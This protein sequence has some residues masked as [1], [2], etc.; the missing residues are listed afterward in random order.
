MAS[1]ATIP[2]DYLVWLSSYLPPQPALGGYAGCVMEADLDGDGAAN[3]LEYLSGANPVRADSAPDWH[4]DLA[5]GVLTVYWPLR[6]DV[7]G[8][9]W[10]LEESED[11][12]VWKA[13]DWIGSDFH[14][15]AGSTWRLATRLDLQELPAG[16]AGHYY[17]VWADSDPP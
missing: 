11:L 7:R 15:H 3:V 12:R 9:T 5:D 14:L 6:A 1:S 17:R 13:A 4:I 2:A 8:V 10:R 16:S